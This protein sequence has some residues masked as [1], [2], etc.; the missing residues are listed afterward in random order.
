MRN[1]ATVGVTVRSVDAERCNPE[2]RARRPPCRAPAGKAPQRWYF[3]RTDYLGLPPAGR[4]RRTGRS[5][6]DRLQLFTDTAAVSRRAEPKHRHGTSDNDTR[7]DVLHKEPHRPGPAAHRS[8]PP[9]S[10]SLPWQAPP[11]RPPPRSYVTAPTSTL[12]ASSGA[13]SPSSTPSGSPTTRAAV[14]QLPPDRARREADPGVRLF[15][16]TG[17]SRAIRRDDPLTPPWSESPDRR[18]RVQTVSFHC[19]YAKRSRCLTSRIVPSFQGSATSHETWTSRRTRSASTCVTRCSR[20]PPSER[21]HR[22]ATQVNSPARSPLAVRRPCSRAPPG[23][24]RQMGTG[25]RAHPQHP[26]VHHP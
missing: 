24:V 17:T 22:R 4:K 21:T 15:P 12:S 8:R 14:T 25:L 3:E 16:A 5:A 9:T 13:A 20:P 11:T 23:I 10:R 26:S 18:F 6:S 19:A 1:C 7:H 2:A